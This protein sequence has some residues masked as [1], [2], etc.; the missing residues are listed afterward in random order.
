MKAFPSL[1]GS[2]PYRRLGRAWLLP[3]LLLCG[4]G[5]AAGVEITVSKT[6]Q[7][8]CC[9]KWVDHL[10]NNGFEVAVVDMDSVEPVKR[11]NGVPAA[12]GSCHTAVVDGYVVEGHVPAD[13]IKRLLNERPK[14]KGLAVPG[15]PMGSPGMEGPQKHPYQVL[16]FDDEG[17]TSVYADR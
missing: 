2:R 3:V 11:Q 7:C 9:K 17:E 4:A 16:T 15:M 12:L 8:G 10:R 14:V 6:P 1:N 13:L 5:G